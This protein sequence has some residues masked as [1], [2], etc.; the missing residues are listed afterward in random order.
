MIWIAFPCKKNVLRIKHSSFYHRGNQNLGPEYSLFRP[1]FANFYDFTRHLFLQ[2]AN[3]KPICLQLT[4]LLYCTYDFNQKLSLIEIGGKHSPQYFIESRINLKAL[5]TA[6][7]KSCQ[8]VKFH[9]CQVTSSCM[10][11]HFNLGQ[12]ISELC[13]SNFS[14]L[15]QNSRKI[16]IKVRMFQCKSWCPTI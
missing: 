2:I 12:N 8:I 5:I 11:K 1:L 10:L 3:A 14:S 6:N 13:V 7:C 4:H 16:H 15:T 9:I